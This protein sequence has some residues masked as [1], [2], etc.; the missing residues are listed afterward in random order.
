[1]ADLI[2]IVVTTFE[3]PDALDAVLRSLAGQT[4]RRFEVVVADDGSGPA[5]AAVIEQWK[6]KIGVPL[7]HVWHEHR[8]FRAA[9]IR[10]RAIRASRGDYCIF[11]DG[12]CLVRRAFVG[13]HRKLAEPGWFVTGN[14]ALLSRLLTDAVLRRQLAPENWP[15]S[16]WIGHRVTGGI[17]RLAPV[18]RLPIGP[19]RKTRPQAWEGARSCNLAV[20]RADLDRVDG[21]DASFSGWGREDSDLLVRLLHAGLRRKDG[22]FATGVLHLWHRDSDR[23]RLPDNEEKLAQ[24]LKSDRV[25]AER[26]MS[27]LGSD[28]YGGNSS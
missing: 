1:M 17:N 2:S 19:L 14:R 15:M 5:T 13:A 24:V 22:Q 21:F 11:L 6:Q 12:D 3:R 8:E 18:M 9:E 10:N 16:F 7:S 26:G 4:D 23:S 27:C 20:W 28:D 25:R